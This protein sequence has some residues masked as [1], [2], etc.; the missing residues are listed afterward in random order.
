MVTI[1]DVGLVLQLEWNWD[2]EETC[3]ISKLNFTSSRANGRREVKGS[4]VMGEQTEETHR[5][6]VQ[7][8][9]SQTEV[10]C[11]VSV[12]L[13]TPDWT[14]W[15]LQSFSCCCSQNLH[16]SFIHIQHTHLL[17]SPVSPVEFF[18]LRSTTIKQ[19]LKCS[20]NSPPVWG[21]QRSTA[22]CRQEETQP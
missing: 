12:S 6:Q 11:V 18:G 19:Q 21:A 4:E 15:V 17:T 10:H 1:K 5:V 7:S 13:Q 20:S 16:N 22:S 2:C 8:G 3:Y 9:W 14:Q